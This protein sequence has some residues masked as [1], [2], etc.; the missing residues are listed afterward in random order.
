MRVATF[1][2]LSGRSPVDDQVDE[3]R[4]AEAVRTLDADV[5]GLQEVDRNQPRSQHH[6][7][8]AG[9]A[10]A[11]GADEHR[12]VAA[13]SGTPGATWSAATGTE[14]PDAA[15]YGVAL[16]SRYP[17][18]GWET[19]R[20]PPV[21]MRVPHRWHGQLRPDWVR[22]EPRVAVVAEVATPS[23]RLSVANTHLSYLPWWN[24]YQLRLLLRSLAE[25]PDP[26]LLMGDLNMG[27]RRAEQ[28]TRMRPLATG[29]T[30]PGHRPVEQ[31]DHLL[32]RGGVTSTGGHAVAL[33]MSDHRAL[34]A[35]VSLA[36]AGQP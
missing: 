2:I 25:R 32:T 15:A 19:V 16:L 20:L 18:L 22:D 24:R 13:L 10:A 4:F 30:F 29:A 35:E 27:R 1:N 9:A 7:L 28:L 11:M 33:P 26:L 6:D 21:P 3:S 5:L 14:Q 17:V 8:T 31:I 23:G 34:L 12:F 36:A